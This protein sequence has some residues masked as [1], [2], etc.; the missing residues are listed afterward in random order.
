MRVTTTK[1]SQLSS[2]CNQVTRVASIAEHQDVVALSRVVNE[3]VSIITA[4]EVTIQTMLKKN[5]DMA[6]LID[7]KK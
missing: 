1:L 4:H 5:L 6:K 2:T 7:D 3:L